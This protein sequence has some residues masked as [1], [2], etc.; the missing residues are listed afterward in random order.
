MARKSAASPA[1]AAESPI[2]D[3]SAPAPSPAAEAEEKACIYADADYPP[4]ASTPAAFAKALEDCGCS[5]CLAALE[6]RRSMVG[7]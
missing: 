6:H 7:P 4:L 3:E 1:L 2:A 5:R